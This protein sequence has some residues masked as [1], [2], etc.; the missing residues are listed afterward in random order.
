VAS[1]RKDL[2]SDFNKASDG[3]LLLPVGETEQSIEGTITRTSILLAIA[4][5][6][7]LKTA[8]GGN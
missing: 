6:V 1:L 3:R 5:P 7:G 8:F 4:V 2:L